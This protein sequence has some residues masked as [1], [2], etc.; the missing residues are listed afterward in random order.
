M[1][2]NKSHAPG[3]SGY[4]QPWGAARM[5]K[6]GWMDGWHALACWLAPPFH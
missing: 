3:I 6:V 5:D 2:R 1:E 4:V